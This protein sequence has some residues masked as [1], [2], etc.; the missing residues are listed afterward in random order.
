MG[1]SICIV[2]REENVEAHDE[3]NAILIAAA[4]ELLEVLTLLNE[5][6]KTAASN[7]VLLTQATFDADE[8]IAKARGFRSL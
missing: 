8:V 2:A 6:A 4:P 1:E 3:A 7:P 5:L